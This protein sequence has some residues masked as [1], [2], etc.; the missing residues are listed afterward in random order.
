[1]SLTTRSIELRHQQ[2]QQQQ[3]QAASGVHSM[4]V[5]AT[6]STISFSYRV[7]VC[8]RVCAQFR[9]AGHLVRI[10]DNRFPKQIFYGQLESGM[11]LPGGP[12]R[13]YKDTLKINLKRCGINPNLLNSAALNRSSWRTEYAKDVTKRLTSS[14]KHVLQLSNAS[15][16]PAST[17]CNLAVMSKSGRVT[18]APGSVLPELG[19]TPINGPIDLDGAVHGCVCV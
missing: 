3:Q 5:T 6:A 4:P 19:C 15:V 10:S 18:A 13:R 7:C 9:W 12:V 8:V 11:R 14:K 1:M 2:Q 16:Q 17:V